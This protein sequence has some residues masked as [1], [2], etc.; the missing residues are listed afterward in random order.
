MNIAISGGAGFVGSWLCKLLLETGNHNV[1]CIDDY[2]GT[3][4]RHVAE[5]KQHFPEQ[6]HIYRADCNCLALMRRLFKTHKIDIVVHCAANARESASQ[7]QPAAIGQRNLAAYL[8]VLSAALS[9]KV[10][11]IICFSSLAV[12]GE[13]KILPPFHETHPTAPEDIY[14]VNKEAMERCTKILCNLHGMAWAVVRPHN[15]FGEWQCLSDPYRNVVG[16]FMNKIMR[17]EPL[18]LFNSGNNIRSF[19]YIL[20]CA[21]ALVNLIENL[22]KH[23]GLTVNIGGIKPIKVLDLAQSVLTAMGET[24]FDLEMAP[25]RPLEVEVAYTTWDRQV[26]HLLYTERYGWEEGVRRMAAWAL[27]Q[28]PQEWSSF[29]EI[30]IDSPLLPKAWREMDPRLRGTV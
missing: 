20:D 16:I 18:V 25:P 6:F 10:K 21:P 3:D 5:I 19:S 24:T 9:E 15:V 14:G 23:N 8:T 4:G 12:Y 28:G 2:S 29:D 1:I 11:G 7:F 26:D 13:G 30:E 27:E 17:K 22:K